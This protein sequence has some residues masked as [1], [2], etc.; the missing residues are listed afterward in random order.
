[1]Q[2]AHA[3]H[4]KRLLKIQGLLG[5]FVVVAALPFGSL[6]ALSALIGAAVCLVAN[7]LFAASVFRGYRAQ[8]PERILLRIYV[9]EAAKLALILGLFSVAFVTIQGLNPPVLLGAY[10]VTQVVSPII[11]AQSEDRGK[12][13]ADNRAQK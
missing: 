6:V 3:S 5:I 10:L 12:S 9:A 1:M 4:V 2:Q 8:E 11:A 13:P 7:A